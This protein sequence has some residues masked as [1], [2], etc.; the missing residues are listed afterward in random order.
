MEM[1][2]NIGK[3]LALQ[4]VVDALKLSPINPSFLDMRDAN[5]IALNDKVTAGHLT[6]AEGATAT[7]CV[8]S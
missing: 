6:A 3:A 4:L 7:A 2:R 8:N 5:L 1:N